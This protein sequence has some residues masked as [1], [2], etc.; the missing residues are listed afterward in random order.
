MKLYLHTIAKSN[1]DI[2]DDNCILHWTQKTDLQ[3]HLLVQL[4]CVALP[5]GL[6][7]FATYCHIIQ[8]LNEIWR[9]R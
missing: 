2:L 1:I 7:I 9:Q 3:R 4:H 8:V 6:K 5:Q